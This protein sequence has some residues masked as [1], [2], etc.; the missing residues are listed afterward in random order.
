[1]RTQFLHLASP[2]GVRNQTSSQMTLCNNLA[3]DYYAV[4]SIPVFSHQLPGGSN[5]KQ[6]IWAGQNSIM[7]L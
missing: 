2:I 1:M 7:N 3:S 6:R 4:H 5:V